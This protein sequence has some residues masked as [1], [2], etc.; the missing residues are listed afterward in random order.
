MDTSEKFK[1]IAAVARKQL[2][3]GFPTESNAT[4]ALHLIEHLA[5]ALAQGSSRG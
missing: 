4:V 1:R 3:G 2:D 5:N